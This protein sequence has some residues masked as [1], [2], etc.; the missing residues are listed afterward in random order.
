[1]SLAGPE[2]KDVDV[3]KA[4]AVGAIA[5]SAVAV[6]SQAG[7]ASADPSPPAKISALPQVFYTAHRGAGAYLAPENTAA[8]FD[9]GVAD[10]NSDVVEFDVQTLADGAGG[11]WH[12]ETVDRISTGTGP[13]GSLTT[14]QFKALTIDAPA[15][16]G[17]GVPSTRPLLLTEV[18]DR[19]GGKKVLLA[20]PKDTPA[21]QLLIKEVTARGLASSVMV[22]TFSLEDAKLAAA[23]GMVTQVLISNTEQ[24]S[25]LT[26]AAIKAAGIPRVSIRG[27]SAD[28]LIKSYVD[29]GLFVCAWGVDRQYRRAQLVN[30]GV[31][32]IDTDDPTYTRGATATYRRTTDPFAN[33]TWWYGHLGQSQTASAV[34]TSQR[35]RF[36]APNYWNVPLGNDP[37]FVRQGWASPQPAT[38]NLR[39]WIRFNALSS[40]RSRWA[41]LYFSGKYDH[42]F[43]DTTNTLNSGYTLIVRQDG[44]LQLY[45]K[46]PTGTTLLKTVNTPALTGGTTAKISLRVTSTGVYFRRYDTTVPGVTVNDT[47]YRGQYLYLGRAAGPTQQGPGVSFYNFGYFE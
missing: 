2:T 6:G 9:R 40:D 13:V 32:G 45:R 44:R 37:L 47:K 12:D 35:G 36:L 29:A 3:G 5:L 26:P 43:N 27:T 39:A 11:V 20:E 15:W 34:G 10:P 33:Q 21:A 41:G 24:A 19:Y 14:A 17:G 42:A 22:Q 4:V 1:V 18:L 30:L 46:D 23:A 7:V 28:S 8:A 38:Y 31:R 25:R 16:F